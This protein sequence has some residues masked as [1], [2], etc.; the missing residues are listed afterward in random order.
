MSYISSL[1]ITFYL[2]YKES[3]SKETIIKYIQFIL[4]EFMISYVKYPA[5]SQTFIYLQDRNAIEFYRKVLGISRFEIAKR[6]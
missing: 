5:Y 3:N 2:K 4:K 6:L 1:E